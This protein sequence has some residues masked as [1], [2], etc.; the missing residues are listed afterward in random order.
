[1][2]S[3]R[4]RFG[5]EYDWRMD[6]EVKWIREW[7]IMESGERVDDASVVIIISEAVTR[8]GL[9]QEINESKL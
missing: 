7:W 5:M 3:I 8:R 1:M 6:F 9:E 2:K 4:N